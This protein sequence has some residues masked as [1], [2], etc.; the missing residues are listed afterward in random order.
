MVRRGRKSIA[1]VGPTAADVRDVMIEGTSGI[2]AVSWAL[3]VDNAGRPMG[4]PVYEPTKRRVT[5][6]NGAMATGFS[7][8]EPDR[9]RGPQ[10]DAAWCD[11]LAAWDNAMDAWDML[12]LGLRIGQNPQVMISTTPR[13]IPII[14]ELLRSKACITT[15]ATTY[16]N[17]AN[18]APGFFD[19]IIQKYEGTRLG[20][21]EIQGQLIEEAE[22]ALWT[23]EMV[24][25]ARD[26]KRSTF[27]RTIVAVDPAVTSGASSNL[28]GIVVGA[29]GHDRRGYVI[30][31]LSGRYRSSL[32]SM[33]ETGPWPLVGY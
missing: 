32:G 10:H 11:E 27:G 17:L 21:Q 22:G 29:V 2:L 20:R 26:G 16:D 18:L 19:R 5:W 9:L 23:R 28:T 12:M 8:Q 24:E 3:D 1:L 6:A 30:A 7:A 4:I 25:R 31:D 13:P 33:L 14:R 15:V